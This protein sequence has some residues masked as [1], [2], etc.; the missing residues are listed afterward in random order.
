MN[1][2]LLVEYD[3]CPPAVQRCI[4]RLSRD[5][6]EERYPTAADIAIQEGL[7]DKDAQELIESF[8]FL[9]RNCWM[10]QS[11]SNPKLTPA[12]LRAL[13]T[14]REA[15]PPIEISDEKTLR[16]ILLFYFFGGHFL[17]A[18]MLDCF[19]EVTAAEAERREEGEQAIRP[20]RR[21]LWENGYLSGD[22]KHHSLSA[23]GEELAESLFQNARARQKPQ[24][25][26]L[27]S[28]W[29]DRTSEGERFMAWAWNQSRGDVNKP[30]DAHAYAVAHGRSRYDLKTVLAWAEEEKLIQNLNPD[31]NFDYRV[32]NFHCESFWDSPV[33]PGI[34]IAHYVYLTTYGEQVGA[35]LAEAERLVSKAT[36]HFHTLS[37]NATV[38]GV[39]G[40]LV[41]GMVGVVGGFYI[42]RATAPQSPTSRTPAVQVAPAPPASAPATA[43]TT[44]V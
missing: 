4:Q 40:G 7:S 21:F 41:G 3:A 39:L 44:G 43:P 32:T 35:Q 11:V 8:E 25:D 28:D 34:P 23:K 22:Q 26:Q 31:G 5:A 38:A 10:S 20:I 9:Q 17:R 14:M 27:S 33:V 18:M 15:L 6:Y 12:A 24:Q 29:K 36:R 13:Y 19:D 37:N 2:E 1:K 30:V 42:G 16:F